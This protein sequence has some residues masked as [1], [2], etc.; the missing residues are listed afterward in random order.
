MAD[1][2]GPASAPNSVTERPVELRAFGMLDTWFRDCSSPAS[3]DGTDIQANWLNGVVAALRALWR[4]NGKKADNVTPVNAEVGTDDAG[5][6]AA[7][8]HLLQRAQQS[9]AVDAGAANALVVT[10]APAP[11]EIKAGMHLRVKV[12]ATNTAAA[13]I[14]VNGAAAAPIK[15]P[16]GSALSAD[17]LIAG[18]VA[19]LVFDGAA[20]QLAATHTDR[21]SEGGGGG[22]AS[23]KVP[24]AVASGTPAAI[25]ATYAPSTPT[26]EA[27][28]LFS[29]KLTSAT[30]GATTFAPDGHGPYGLKSPNGSALTAGYAL[31]GDLLLLEFD[32][33][34][35]IVLSKTSAVLTPTYPVFPEVGSYYW[36]LTY[37]PNPPNL[38]VIGSTLSIGGLP[39]AWKLLGTQQVDFG[40]MI[41][42]VTMPMSY[43]NFNFYQRI[44]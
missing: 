8:L 43:I 1:I 36:N 27:G 30:V 14:A 3:E 40:T 11:A 20:W 28:H 18:G 22:S 35:F 10:L 21:L 44:A 33:A 25:T 23:F 37:G 5:L 7:M 4:V 9:Y 31:A 42:G 38:G 13:T 24:Y 12:A 15:H 39:G 26:P 32:G 29:V 17:D 6:A 34:N 2:L 19:W 41:S 16:D